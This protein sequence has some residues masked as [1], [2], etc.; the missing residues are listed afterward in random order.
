MRFISV[1][2]IV[3]VFMDVFREGVEL[4]W[5]SGSDLVL[6]GSATW[7]LAGDHHSLKEQLTA[8]DAPGLTPLECA[9][10]AECLDRAL[11]A[12]SLGVLHVAGRL[13]EEQLRVVHSARQQ[14][15]VDPLRCVVEAP[16]SRP[17]VAGELGLID[18]VENADVHVSPPYDLDRWV[19]QVGQTIC[20]KQKGRGSRFGSAAWRLPSVEFQ[21]LGGLQTEV[22]GKAP[23]TRVAT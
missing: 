4:T 23:L 8:P 3:F 21:Q 20:E 18:A 12:Q 14:L 1:L 9:G 5:R 2:R 13:G 7:A 16:E 15:I 11:L 6:A 10:E 17:R 19:W 22:P